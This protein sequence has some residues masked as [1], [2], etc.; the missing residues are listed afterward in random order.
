LKSWAGAALLELTPPETLGGSLASD[1]LNEA[2]RTAEMFR[3][4][5]YDRH[6][7]IDGIK[8]DFRHPEIPVSK[9][10]MPTITT[11]LGTLG[12]AIGKNKPYFWFPWYGNFESHGDNTII[13]DV[14]LTEGDIISIAE[15]KTQII[16]K[17]FSSL[18]D[19]EVKRAFLR[20]THSDG[21]TETIRNSIIFR[22]AAAVVEGI[23]SHSIFDA[24]SL[25]IMDY[26]KIES[27]RYVT[28][29]SAKSEAEYRA[30]SGASIIEEYFGDLRPLLEESPTRSGDHKFAFDLWDVI[31]SAV[32]MGYFWAQVEAEAEILPLAGQAKQI[33]QRAK[34]A[35]LKSGASRRAKSQESWRDEAKHIALTVRKDKPGISQDELATEILWSLKS[36]NPPKHGTVKTYL[37]TLEREGTLPRNNRRKAK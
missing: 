15:V 17:Q 2:R 14:I 6:G 1:S 23:A 37:V 3:I 11:R 27:V 19:R 29:I 25:R 33:E 7:E 31:N 22:A 10:L 21:S 4:C 35:G 24:L 9:W 28:G 34:D 32:G 30:L 20:V 36:E 5:R 26:F 16:G 12:T 8:F 18:P 13:P